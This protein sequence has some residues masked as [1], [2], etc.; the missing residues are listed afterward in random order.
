MSV[1]IAHGLPPRADVDAL[2][3]SI[4]GR[5][6]LPDDRDYDDARLVFLGDV[7]R[8][9]GAIVRVAGAADVARVIAFAREHDVE[10][11]V[12]SGGHSNAGQSTTDGG[13]VLDVRDLR[14]IDLD[15]E[16]KSV[17]AGA[18]LT[19]LDLTTVNF[20]QD[21]GEDRVRAAYPSP[22][23]ERLTALKR[24]YDP[25]NVFRLNQNIPPGPAD[26]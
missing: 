23:W 1:H 6:I 25:T 15:V 14:A 9:P 10:L 12:R 13:L 18:G 21:E 17:W 22:T 20:L 24:R 19:A 16:G 2:A 26:A 3:A 11:A 7:D 4:D 8:R 5:V